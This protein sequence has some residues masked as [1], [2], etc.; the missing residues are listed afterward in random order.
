[1]DLAVFSLPVAVT[2]T[3]TH[4]AYPQ[5]NGQAE[6]ATMRLRLDVL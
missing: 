1:M 5:R 4:C 6:L 3:S 2:I